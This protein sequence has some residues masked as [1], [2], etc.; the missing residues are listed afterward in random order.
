MISN[1]AAKHIWDA[2]RAAERI[3]SFTAGQTFDDYVSNQ[4]L[5]SA[6]ERQFEII[7]EA[8]LRLRRTD[9]DVAEMV[10]EINKIIGFRNVLV[11]DYDSVDFRRVWVT[12][13]DDLP[14]LI[15][16]L[17]DLLRQAPPLE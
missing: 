15:S 13:Q 6:I 2:R 3:V 10:P 11:H 1:R 14:K 9:P 4:M 7:G 12:V 16:I 17:T 8:L 5:S